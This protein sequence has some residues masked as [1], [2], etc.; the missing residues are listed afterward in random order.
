MA[1][2]RVETAL[3]QASP[4]ALASPRSVCLLMEQMH[5]EHRH[6]VPTDSP[7]RLSSLYKNPAVQQRHNASCGC[8]SLPPSMICTRSAKRMSNASCPSCAYVVKHVASPGQRY[9]PALGHRG[10]SNAL[11]PQRHR[12]CTL[13]A[14]PGLRLRSPTPQ[15]RQSASG[16]PLERGEV[17]FKGELFTTQTLLRW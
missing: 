15:P 11:V 3:S 1:T 12:A 9:G 8:L 14:P 17:V 10:I 7:D 13:W 4:P 6:G 2:S 16:W 5:L